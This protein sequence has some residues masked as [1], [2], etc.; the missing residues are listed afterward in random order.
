MLAD[1]KLKTAR[2]VEVVHWRYHSDFIRTFRT[3]W[4]R[5]QLR[6]KKF[7]WEHAE[8]KEEQI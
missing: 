8:A 3:G 6:R 7:W 2:G 5:G 4:N 1:E